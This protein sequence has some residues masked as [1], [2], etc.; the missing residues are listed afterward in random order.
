M[1]MKYRM[2]VLVLRQLN[3]INK[4]IQAAHSCL[5]YAKSFGKTDEYID[6]I[7]ND[8]TII[9]LDGGTSNDLK[10][11]VKTLVENEINFEVFNEPDLNDSIT[12][13]SFLADERVFDYENYPDYD[14]WCNLNN[15]MMMVVNT[16]PPIILDGEATKNRWLSLIGGNKNDILRKIIKNKRLSI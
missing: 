2:Y 14:I 9:V 15:V 6:F 10:D 12:A 8:K 5:E 1:N 4:G 7:N 11:I 13:I 16:N 3:G